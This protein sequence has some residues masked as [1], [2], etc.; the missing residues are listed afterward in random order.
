VI[1]LLDAGIPRSGDEW[2]PDTQPTGSPW[3]VVR[4]TA[5]PPQL[6]LF[7]FPYAG[8]ATAV[9]YR[10]SRQFPAGVQVCPIE[11]P[12]RGVRLREAPFRRILPLVE[13]VAQGLP[14]F[15]DRPFALFG[16]S[17]GAWI[18]FE[19]AR[20]LRDSR[21]IVPVHLLVSA[22]R[23]PHLPPTRSSIHDLPDAEFRREL[24]RLSGTPPEVLENDDYMRLMLPGIRADFEMFECHAFQEGP[25][26]TCPV[27][28]LGGWE[29]PV[30]SRAELEA[31]R[32]HTT[33]QFALRMFPGDHFFLLDPQ[34]EVRPFVEQTL[35]DAVAS[36][37]GSSRRY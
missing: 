34:A 28:A 18:A 11:L 12:G 14:A 4:T 19:L 3:T 9:Y 13:A 10:W 21:G 33:G 22:S 37:E 31:W 5:T 8:G 26:L 23:A 30:V 6:R 29:D 2:M 25:P 36:V 7:C 35:R 20:H 1:G 16:H 17:L 27:T 24:Q 15:W 32:R